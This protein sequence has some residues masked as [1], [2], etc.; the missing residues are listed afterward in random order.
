MSHAP[1]TIQTDLSSVLQEILPVLRR[2]ATALLQGLQVGKLA[3][4][5]ERQDKQIVELLRL[6]RPLALD[7]TSTSPSCLPNVMRV[8]LL[9]RAARTEDTRS[10]GTRR[11]TEDMA[12]AASVSM[13]ATHLNCSKDFATERLQ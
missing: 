4:L 1:C 5:A 3:I 12:A 13:S 10:V 2:D 9:L 7:D 8:L 6:G 11:G